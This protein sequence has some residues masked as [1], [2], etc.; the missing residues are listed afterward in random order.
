MTA[1]RCT[2]L[3]SVVLTPA[4]SASSKHRALD[5]EDHNAD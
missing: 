3:V 5:K 4:L 2:T 1:T